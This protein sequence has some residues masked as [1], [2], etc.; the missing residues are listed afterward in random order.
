M[1][2]PLHDIKVVDLTSMGLRPASR[3]KRWPTRVRT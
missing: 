3:R 1:P 2:G